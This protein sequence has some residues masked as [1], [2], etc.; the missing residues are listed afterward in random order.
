MSLD[1]SSVIA[2]TTQWLIR[3]YPAADGAMNA[4]LAEAQARQA[5]TLATLLRYA[6]PTDC[7][8]APLAGPDGSFRLDWLVDA[9]PYEISGPDGVWRTWVDE[10]VASWAAALLT[11]STLAS[12]AVAALG[13]CEHGGGS[14]GEWRRLTAPDALDCRAAPLLR[15]PDL[16]ALV[17]DLHRPQLVE[18][19]RW[20]HSDD[21]TPTSAV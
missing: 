20:L 1:L 21:Q 3:A 5:V 2:A 11:C 19:L 14:P 10:V 16:T 7:P 4:A 13:D 17:V 8:L 6:T 9:E 15:H 12:Q 18:R